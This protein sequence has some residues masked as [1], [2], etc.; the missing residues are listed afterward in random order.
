MYFFVFTVT[1]ITDKIFGIKESNGLK[2]DRTRKVEY[3]L[4]GVFLTAIAKVLFVEGR[5]RTRLYLQPN[6]SLFSNLFYF[7][8]ILSLNPTQD[9]LFG[10]S[11]GLR[12]GRGGKKT[13]L[14]KICHTYTTMIKLGTVIPYLR[15]ILKI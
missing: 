8:E 2:L 11:H 15:K 10:A 12:G 9:G 7:S 3:L 14:P 4:L 1:I 13:P 6:L 5:M